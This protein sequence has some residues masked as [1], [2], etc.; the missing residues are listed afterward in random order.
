VVP[1]GDVGD[2]LPHGDHRSRCLV[3]QDR[4]QQLGQ[5]AV[6]QRQVGVADPRGGD[7]HPHLTGPGIGKLDVTDHQRLA[8]G[9][10]HRGT[11]HGFQQPSRT[12]AR[13]WPTPMQIAARP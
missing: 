1:G 12:L 9:A 13:P 7:A 10:Q 8:E 11:D 5:G 4:G 3:A 6:R 2:P